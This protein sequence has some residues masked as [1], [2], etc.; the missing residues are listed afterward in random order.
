MTTFMLEKI[1]KQCPLKKQEVD[2]LFKFKFLDNEI[3]FTTS[4]RMQKNEY[5]LDVS[6]AASENFSFH[7]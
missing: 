7:R 5:N 4:L 6:Y 2:N 1:R 3:I